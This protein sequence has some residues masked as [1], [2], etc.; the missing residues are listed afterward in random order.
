MYIYI[1]IYICL[2]VC[3]C[4]LIWVCVWIRI[5]PPAHVPSLLQPASATGTASECGASEKI[6]IS[7]D[8]TML[9]ALCSRYAALTPKSQTSRTTHGGLRKRKSRN[10]HT[11]EAPSRFPR[12]ERKFAVTEGMSARIRYSIR[13]SMFPVLVTGLQGAAI[14]SS[15]DGS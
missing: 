14:L 8:C 4:V 15:W 11:I 2:C 3:V 12:V 5:W 13:P 10:P 9:N 1:H 6:G 7:I